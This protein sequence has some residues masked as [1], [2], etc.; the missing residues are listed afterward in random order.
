MRAGESD[1]AA[2]GLRLCTL[3]RGGVTEDL[4]FSQ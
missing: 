3:I 4:R 1:G 2:G